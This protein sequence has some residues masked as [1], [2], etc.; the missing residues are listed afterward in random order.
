MSMAWNNKNNG[1]YCICH[2]IEVAHN[3]KIS[4]GAAATSYQI[5]RH[6]N[7]F[8]KNAIGVLLKGVTS[9]LT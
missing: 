6:I 3:F 1:I 5:K 2:I 4:T 8:V 9:Q 7:L